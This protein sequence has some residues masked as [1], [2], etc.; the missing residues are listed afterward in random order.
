[1]KIADRNLICE[2][3]IPPPAYQHLAPFH[4]LR[5]T[6][7]TKLNGWWGEDGTAFLKTSVK[8]QNRS[9]PQQPQLATNSPFSI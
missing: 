4:W 9:A 2:S 1:V 5:D 8:P 3:S 6:E 7:Q